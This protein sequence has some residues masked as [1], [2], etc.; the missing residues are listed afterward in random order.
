MEDRHAG[1]AEAAATRIDFADW[2]RTLPQK[3]CKIINVLATGE[4]TTNTARKFKVSPGRI[5]QVRS[6][7]R[8]DWFAFQGEPVPS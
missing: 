8:C 7:L 2:L 4:S 3:K 1:P 6:E 5:S